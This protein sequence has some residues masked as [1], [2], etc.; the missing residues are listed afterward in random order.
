MNE[1]LHMRTQERSKL[2]FSDF[3]ENFQDMQS[4]VHGRPPFY[5][6]SEKFNLAQIM[7]RSGINCGPLFKLSS[8][9]ATQDLPEFAVI[10]CKSAELRSPEPALA[11]RTILIS[12]QDFDILIDDLQNLEPGSVQQKV[13]SLVTVFLSYGNAVPV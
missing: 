6:T 9:H 8:L 7:A 2:G 11:G 4:P 5:Q 1:N 3:C 12:K 10:S 13:L